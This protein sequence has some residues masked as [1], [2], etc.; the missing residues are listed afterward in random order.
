MPGL[1][2]H[3]R[4]VFTFHH[5]AY[6][7][8]RAGRTQQHT[9]FSIQ[10][11]FHRLDGSL[12]RFAAIDINAPCQRDI[13]HELGIFFHPLLQ[14]VQSDILLHHGRQHLQGGYH[15]ITGR[16][17]VQAD[18]MPGRFTTQHTV[19]LLEQFHHIAV[20][21]PGAFEIYLLCLQG[22]FHT[23]IGHE[24]SDHRAEQLVIFLAR[25]GNDKQQ[26]IAIDQFT[27]VI[28]HNEA[29]TVSIQCD[30]EISLLFQNPFT[31]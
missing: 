23:Q 20:A 17:P 10:L 31:Q 11:F 4:L 13:D 30:A 5:D 15:A 1:L 27:L 19:V 12:N 8:F 18:D 25:Y 3:Q 26:F 28:N 24:R 29:V 7:W 16:G 21:H 6:Q 9:A 14:L 22:M 2:F